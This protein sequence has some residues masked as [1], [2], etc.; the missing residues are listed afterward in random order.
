MAE[1]RKPFPKFD[2]PMPE[3]IYGWRNL[4]RLVGHGRSQID[5]WIAYESF[6]RPTRETFKRHQ[7]L[8]KRSEVEKWIARLA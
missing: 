5:R 6:P 2:L 7:L 3:N 8:W 4:Q 1:L